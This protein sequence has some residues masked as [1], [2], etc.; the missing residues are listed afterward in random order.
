[1]TNL[2]N[3]IE[4]EDGVITDLDIHSEWKNILKNYKIM[5]LGGI[6]GLGK[7]MQIMFFAK[8]KYRFYERI[9]C[10]N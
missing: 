7:T 10:S 1:M 2:N 8:S 3:I 5:H 4:S 6:S 9:D